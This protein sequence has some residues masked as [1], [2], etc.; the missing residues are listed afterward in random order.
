[1]PTC[2][3]APRNTYRTAL[4]GC[5]LSLSLIPAPSLAEGLDLG[6]G[7]SLVNGPADSFDS[8]WGLQL[9][10]EFPAGAQWGTGLQLELTEGITTEGS[11]QSEGDLAY[12]S[13]SLYLTLRPRGGWLQAKAGSVY[14]DYR[15]VMGDE[16]RRGY[17]VGLALV[18]GGDGLI[19]HLLDYQHQVF[20]G[21]HFDVVTIS[22]TVMH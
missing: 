14:A 11:V 13:A 19:W 1:M 9:G 10:Y 7:W 17:G 4:L 5:L 22:L 2:T 6:A 15:T 21:D 16:S 20:D 3:M 12:S 8:G 18:G